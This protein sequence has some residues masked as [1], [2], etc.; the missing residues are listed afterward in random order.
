MN[1]DVS[2]DM[3]FVILNPDKE[4]T[5]AESLISSAVA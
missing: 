3:A 1:G 2:R 4:K 5:F